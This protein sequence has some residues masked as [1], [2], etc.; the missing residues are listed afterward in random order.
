MF[1]TT[2]L[3]PDTSGLNAATVRATL[4]RGFRARLLADPHAAVRE[5]GVELPPTLRLKFIEK[6]DDVDL[7]VVLPDLLGEL[8]GE[9]LEAVSG[10]AARG[11]WRI[12]F[13][14]PLR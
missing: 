6:G 11:L 2:P 1:R 13:S 12:E 9:V 3:A 14:L 4:D 7:L 8:P 5:L 10:G